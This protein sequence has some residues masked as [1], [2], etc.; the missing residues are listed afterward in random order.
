MRKS[1]Y[2]AVFEPSSDGG[3]GVY[4]PDL[5]GCVS[6]GATYDEAEAMAKEALEL[7][8]YGMEK[9]SDE[10][11]AP[12]EPGKLVIDPETTSGYLVSQITIF[13]DVVKNELDNRAVRTNITI[14]AWLKEL[15]ELKKVN[16]SQLFTAALKEYLS[17]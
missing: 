16:F 12:S 15:A 13:P 14:P 9:D 3:Y 5:P 2:F 7:H 4:F 1:T 10:I 17:V 11:P 6:Y 8:L